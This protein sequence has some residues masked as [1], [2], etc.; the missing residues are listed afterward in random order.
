MASDSA[1]KF[2]LQYTQKLIG[3]SGK[4]DWIGMNFIR[5]TVRKR[6]IT[7]YCISCINQD[8]IVCCFTRWKYHIGRKIIQHIV[9][10]VYCITNDAQA[11]IVIISSKI[12][13]RLEPSVLY[14]YG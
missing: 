4:S 11:L 5:P 8:K 9:K 13:R 6:G 1:C 12:E 3:K 14:T 2:G 10:A 7:G